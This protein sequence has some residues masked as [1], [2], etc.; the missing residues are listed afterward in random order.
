MSLGLMI[1]GFI[2]FGLS[3]LGIPSPPRF[4]LLSAG[5]ACW[6]LAEIIGRGILH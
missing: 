1:A 3:T 4:S 2:L 6:I 5:L